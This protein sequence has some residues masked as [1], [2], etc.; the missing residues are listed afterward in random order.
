MQKHFIPN[1]NVENANI[2]PAFKNFSGEK[3]NDGKRGFAWKIEDQNVAKAMKE[4][5]WRVKVT[6]KDPDMV[7]QLL[8][9][10]WASVNVYP[11]LTDDIQYRLEIAVNL[12]PPAGVAPAEIYTHKGDVTNRIDQ[13]T[14]GDLDGVQFVN[15]DMTISPRWWRDNNGEWSVK[16]YLRIMHITLEQ[17]PWAS[18]YPMYQPGME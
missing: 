2:L 9:E 18:K 11:E 12:N 10:G 14:C 16:A 4:D 15:V 5:G 13:E 6:V 3:W 1:I 8:D 7:K 17:D